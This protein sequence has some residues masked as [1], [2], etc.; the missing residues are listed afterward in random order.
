MKGDEHAVVVPGRE[1]L[2]V[3]PHHRIRCPVRGKGCNRSALGRAWTKL[4]APVA[5]VFGSED[6]FPLYRIVVALRPAVVAAPSQEKQLFCR[7][8]R[9]LLGLVESRPIR[10]QL[11]TS[12]LCNKEMVPRR[13]DGEAFGIAYAGRETLRR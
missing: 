8:G 10:T 2:A 3:V 4:L 9:L 5:A 12:V 7:K 13:I 6:Q 11:V 1:L